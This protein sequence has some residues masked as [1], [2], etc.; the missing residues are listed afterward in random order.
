AKPA[1]DQEERLGDVESG[2][3]QV[4]V[5][6]V[7]ERVFPHEPVEGEDQAPDEAGE[8]DREPRGADDGKRG[9]ALLREVVH[10][11]THTESPRPS[12]PG[13][14]WRGGQEPTPRRGLPG[15]GGGAVWCRRLTARRGP[16]AAAVAPGAAGAPA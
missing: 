3:S 8:P 5:E 15:L 9:A 11:L 4:C 10:G 12:I 13:R 7:V 14:W 1:L 16:A 2:Q 6:F